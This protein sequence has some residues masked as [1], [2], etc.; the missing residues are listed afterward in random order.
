MANTLT[1]ENTGEKWTD[2]IHSFDADDVV[3]H[4][5][6][7]TSEDLVDRQSDV[8]DFGAS[9]EGANMCVSTAACQPGKGYTKIAY[10]GVDEQFQLMTPADGGFL[11]RPMGWER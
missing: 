11:G 7:E 9:Y 5:R 8:I 3:A 1:R 2:E 6:N 4:A 10:D